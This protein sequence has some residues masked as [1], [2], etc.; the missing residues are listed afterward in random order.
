[1]PC[2]PPPAYSVCVA[3][4]AAIDHTPSGIAAVGASWRQPERWRALQLRASNAAT[5][6]SMCSVTNSVPV[7]LSSSIQNGRLPVW[8]VRSARP[9]PDVSRALHVD[10]SSAEIVSESMLSTN[11]VRLAWSITRLE[12]GSLPTRAVASCPQP[13]ASWPLQVAASNTDT[14]RSFAFST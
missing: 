10:A 8:T 5:S 7:G 2:S 11:S 3:G 12:L 1:M 6:S 4:S 13:D 9:Q 14:F